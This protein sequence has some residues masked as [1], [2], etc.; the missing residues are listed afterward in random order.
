[1]CASTVAS[2]CSAVNCASACASAEAAKSCGMP[3]RTWPVT[4]RCRAASASSLVRIISRAY[5]SSAWPCS[6]SA[7][8]PPARWNSATPAVASS[9][10]ICWLMAAVLRERC[11]P[12]MRMVPVSATAT[13]LR[14]KAMSKDLI[15]LF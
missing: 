12:A 1:M 9:A 2:G 10:R 3:K 14:R 6:D 5:G 4:A 15:K 13:K 11:A 8:L 7:T